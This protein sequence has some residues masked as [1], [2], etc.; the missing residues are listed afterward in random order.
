MTTCLLSATP[1]GGPQ[2]R[3]YFHQA[4]KGMAQYTLGLGVF[5]AAIWISRIHDVIIQPCDQ[6]HL[7]LQILD[8]SL[9]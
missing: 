2:N 6:V 1:Y 5:H 8:R 9:V 4:P 3:C 7:L